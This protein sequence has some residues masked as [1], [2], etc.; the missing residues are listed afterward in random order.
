[1]GFRCSPAEFQRWVDSGLIPADEPAVTADPVGG[2][3]ACIEVPP[4]VNNLF[5]NRGKFRV[6]SPKYRAWLERNAM[7]LGLQLRKPT[8]F[9][10]RLVITIL[11]GKGFRR[12]RDIS[13]ITKA[14]EDACVFSGLL[15]DDSVQYVH[16]VHVSYI[17][18]KTKEPAKCLVRLERS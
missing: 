4:S 18:R 16:A 11:G 8:T 3:V 15:P 12:N 7:S 5:L 13:N 9:P 1:M 10:I 2:P 6:K 17:D 14:A